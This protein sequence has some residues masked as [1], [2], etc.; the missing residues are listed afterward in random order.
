MATRQQ[1]RTANAI[2]SVIQQNATLRKDNTA[3][4]AMVKRLRDELDET[5]KPAKKAKKVS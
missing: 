5:K 1:V 2:K 4:I 3:L